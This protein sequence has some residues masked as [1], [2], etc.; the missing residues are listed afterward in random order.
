MRT[1]EESFLAQYCEED[2]DWQRAK[3]CFCHHNHQNIIMIIIQMI[4]VNTMVFKIFTG[5]TEIS[6]SITNIIIPAII[7]NEL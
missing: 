3:L 2:C 4:V 6:G 7:T 5:I 1:S